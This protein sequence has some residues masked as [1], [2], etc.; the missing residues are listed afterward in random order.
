MKPKDN[1]PGDDLSDISDEDFQFIET[2]F[3]SIIMQVRETRKPHAAV[4]AI[5]RQEDSDYVTMNH[6]IIG[7]EPASP[8]DYPI[9]TKIVGDKL[10][11]CVKQKITEH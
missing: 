7:R 10:L 5:L 6:S 11:E 8:L 4:I 9:I 2:M 1:F 3:R